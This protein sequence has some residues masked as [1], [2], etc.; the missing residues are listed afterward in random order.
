MLQRL[1]YSS[2]ESPAVAGILREGRTAFSCSAA[3]LKTKVEVIGLAFHKL[4]SNSR[5]EG[6]DVVPCN[7]SG[8]DGSLVTIVSGLRAQFRQVEITR[9]RSY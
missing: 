6:G 4:A 3:I 2:A 5:W 8:A 9:C 1:Q 7:L